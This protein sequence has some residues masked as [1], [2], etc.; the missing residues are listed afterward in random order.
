MLYHLKSPYP[1]AAVQVESGTKQ[2]I[3]SDTRGCGVVQKQQLRA[4]ALMVEK[5]MMP[6]NVVMCG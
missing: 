5:D 4:F 3:M 6:I 2:T 1:T